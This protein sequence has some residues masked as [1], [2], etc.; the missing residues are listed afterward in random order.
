M[1]LDL[2]LEQKGFFPCLE[3]LLTLENVNFVEKW[4][5]H[6]IVLKDRTME[7]IIKKNKPF[8]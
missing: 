3:F 2:K 4:E 8:I 7:Y 6:N 5:T 1:L